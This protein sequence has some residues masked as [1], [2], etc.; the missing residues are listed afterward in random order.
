MG[1]MASFAVCGDLAGDSFPPADVRMI[2]D[3]A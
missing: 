3:D 1:N 2:G